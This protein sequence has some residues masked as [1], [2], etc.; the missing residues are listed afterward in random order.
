MRQEDCKSEGDLGNL[1][2]TCSETNYKKGL[3]VEPSSTELNS[4]MLICWE[5]GP[6]LLPTTKGTRREGETGKRKEKRKKKRKEGKEEKGREGSKGGKERQR[7]GGS[8][9]GRKEERKKWGNCLIKY[10]NSENTE[11]L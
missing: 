6:S 2:R 11:K 5:Q 8:K 3:E 1:E 10:A 9:E 4:T 7:E